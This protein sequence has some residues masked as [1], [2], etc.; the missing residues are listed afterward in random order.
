MYFDLLAKGFL[1]PE[2]LD[3]PIEGF[4][5]YFDALRELGT[6]RPGGM[7]IQPIPFTAIVEYFRIYGTG[8]FEEFNYI[9]RR[10]DDTLL[11]LSRSRREREGNKKNGPAN[12]DP[13]NPNSGRLQR[14]SRSQKNRR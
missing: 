3:P 14:Q 2:D 12:A 8:D 1:K 13:N 6:C 11:E 5:G 4:E 7:D 9:I 10:L